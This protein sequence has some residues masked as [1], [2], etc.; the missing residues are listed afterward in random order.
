MPPLIPRDNSDY[1]T[2]PA[3]VPDSALPALPA[4][5]PHPCT[6]SLPPPSPTTRTFT[7]DVPPKIWR[8][9]P[10]DRYIPVD[11]S[12]DIDESV[13]EFEQYGKAICHPPE[14]FTN[15][16]TD[17]HLWDRERD[18]PEF[19]KNFNISPDVD[20]AIRT[21]IVDIIESH[22]DCFYGAGVKFPILYFEFA[23]DT[24]ASPPVCCKKP[25][26]G[27]HESKII[28]THVDVLKG[29]GWIRR[30]FGPWGSSIVLAAKP[31]QEHIT[32][33]LEFIWR[34]CVSYRRLNQVT[35]PF[36][37]P[38]PRCDDAI[39]NFGDSA[40]RLYFIALDNKTGYHQIKVRECDQ[41]K[42]AFFAPD[43]EKYCFGVMP[44]GPRNAPAFYTCMMRIFKSEWQALYKSRYPADTAHLGSRI[45]IDDILLW[46][47]IL[48]A[49]LRLFEC[50][51]DVFMKYRVTFQLKKC[52][53][54]TNRIEY[55]GHD[56]TPDGNCPAESKFDLVND[57]PL[58]VNGQSLGS[59]I[60]LLTFYNIYCPF[61]EMRVKPLRSLERQHHRKPIPC[62]MWTPS[63]THLWDELKLAVT[64]S[65]CL[66]RYDSSLPCFLKTDWAGTGMGWIL[67]QPDNSEASK[68]AL[69]L[70][71][72][73]GICTFDL[74]MNGARLR[75]IRFG[76]RSCTERERHYHSFVGEAACGRW[77]IG[78]NR[79]F[80]WGSEFYWLCDCSAVKEI[81]EYDGP[82]HQI[83][84]WAQELL[85]YFFQVFHRPA[86]MMRD[87][88]GLTRFDH[89]L[90]AQ[91]LKIA[92]QLYLADRAARPAA[93]DPAVFSSHPNPLKCLATD[94]PSSPAPVLVATSTA[95][96]L[97]T[98][99]ASYPLHALVT[100][101]PVRFRP[102]PTL[103][104]TD[105]SLAPNSTTCTGSHLLLS[106]RT[107]A[108]LSLTPQ[109]GAI[110]F[111]L[112]THAHLFPVASVVI[113]PTSFPSTPLCHAALPNAFFVPYS[114]PQ[115]T[116]HLS[117]FRTPAVFDPA[118]VDP[119]L[120]WFFD[121]Y[122]RIT[123]IDCSCPF[124]D[125]SAQLDWLRSVLSLVDFLSSQ[126][127]L[128]CFVLFVNLKADFA[129]GTDLSDL[130]LHWRQDPW[131]LQMGPTTSALYTDAVHSR[132]W[133]CLG[134]RQ[135]GLFPPPV[136]SFPDP[137]PL[138]SC[139]GDHVLSDLN[140]VDDDC[141]PLPASVSLISSDP[142]L[143]A[144]VPH[145]LAILQAAAPPAALSPFY[146]LDPD[147][148]AIEPLPLINHL[149]HRFSATFGVPFTSSLGSNHV[150]P[151]STSEL[152]ACYSVPS[153]VIDAIPSTADPSTYAL[154]LSTCCPFGLGSHLVDHLI[155]IHLFASIDAANSPTE[156]VT[157]SLVNT[158]SGSR[159]IPSPLDWSSAYQQDPDT[160][161]MLKRLSSSTPFSKADIST[162]HYAY[163]DYIRQ[164]RLALH[165]GKLVVF[166]PVQNNSEM[167]MLI[168]V[169]LSLRRDIFSAYH[170]SPSTGHMGIY[171]T[172]HRIR[173]RF[174]WP[175]SRKDVT[176]WVLQC[177]H[178]IAS[179][180]TV[181]RNSELIFSW[182]LCCPFYILHVDLWAPGEIANYRGE[183]Y[184]MNSMCDLTGF[185]LVTATNDTTAHNLARLLVQDV[186][187][188]V[189]FCGL[190]VVDDGSTFK[191]LFK[192][193]CSLLN[194]DLHVA[195]RGNHKAVGVEHFHR[196]LNKA[197]AIAGNDRGTNTVFV[198]AAHT[199]AYAWNSS[200]IDGT[201]IIR[202]VPAV[203]RPFR[204]PF[205]LSL[206]PTPTPTQQQATDV[207]AFLRLAGPTAQFAEQV[208]RLL[209]DERRAIHRERAN[210]SRSPVSFAIGDLV[211][212]TVQVNSD[213]ATG[214]VAKL[215]YRK[216][217]PYVIIEST[218]FGAYLVQRH[219]HP[220]SPL[221]KYPTQALSPLP[222]AL[223]P[224]TPIDTP[225]FRYLNHSHA[226]L[227]HPLKSPFGIQMYNNKWFTS[228]LPTDHPP[229]FEFQDVTVTDTSDP[230]TLPSI[231][232]AVSI[233][234]AAAVPVYPSTDPPIPSIP[235]TNA[236][237]HAALSLSPDKL[238]FVSYRPSGTLR[239]RW[240]LIQVDL[241]QSLLASADCVADG[242]YYCHFL[243]R[244]PDDNSLPDPPS[245]WWLLWHRFT[246][247]PDDSIEF[248]PR[249]LFKPT[250][251][252]DPASY[253]AWADVLP[254]LDPSVCLLGPFSF[255]EPASNPPGRTSSY[256][257][258]LPFRLWASLTNICISRG[259][260]PP[261]LS[262]P[263]T[264]RSRWTRSS[265]RPS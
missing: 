223:L 29:N 93:Y 10:V 208:L 156:F 38:I 169:P 149:P 225:D 178:C 245:R 216:R 162:L 262:S 241:P 44:F 142:L 168:V 24:G 160:Q 90:I 139:L 23:I 84:R 248:G 232:P 234:A 114:L 242:R 185:V 1:D 26:Y 193:V 119:T 194:I 87:V 214:T 218:G 62:A 250:T 209:T 86:R 181:A 191:G 34:L 120:N 57:W 186:L 43:D 158:V 54:L 47:T 103:P 106:N 124:I 125:L 260:L 66:A 256:R 64:S 189:G 251:T 126:F 211:M 177:P 88:D 145:P 48:A 136:P 192:A 19:T 140:Q 195:A 228:P 163:R 71:R 180:G 170:A 30:C 118:S 236:S 112:D 176:A 83:R 127:R 28:M 219:G 171:K 183:T 259:I 258:M 155:D 146:V 111:A 157:R 131:K 60:G 46:A 173:L 58:P 175:V 137:S 104:I 59:F 89:P 224:C 68:V 116:R 99:T 254:L 11:Y 166:Q 200:P 187:L 2:P 217:G 190:I 249:V 27:P 96:P 42:L 161:L 9:K 15:V 41:E 49:L 197:V 109:L 210:A 21:A 239:P 121:R 110:P 230:P 206:S 4:L 39:D 123:G 81:L 37:Y 154:S 22:W 144:T 196:F 85:G 253:I 107:V 147:Y 16:R 164:D 222:P 150:R 108:W 61:F 148:P 8:P 91:H 69:A 261:I 167:L 134:L 188:K 198:E 143:P 117:L 184:L 25:R 153:S 128:S 55:V 3:A 56:I 12:N 52:E 220:G 265:P 78:Q 94:T 203:G 235:I 63:L 237:L 75:P 65:P 50:V 244:H 238:F 13:F 45:I 264:T 20:P 101:L 113:Q 5:L 132:R 247:L 97:P 199:A 231:R 36:E 72:S 51:C 67:M 98:A 182:P 7:I 35:L 115:L 263:P 165:D 159:P 105:P 172:L 130:A 226:P 174:F 6:D 122:P 141:I 205:D 215:A 233:P 240:Y 74:T 73:E 151:F 53:F 95:A 152:F 207:H 246:S 221:V 82:I 204:F 202:S 257:Q 227:I 14:P 92:L 201:D 255:T 179:N 76:S 77:A 138:S 80:L 17:I 252:P 70:L 135:I 229:L 79:K 102:S 243:G 32:D 100:N 18:L 129:C 212:A 133:V 213:A 40:G 31:H 33:I